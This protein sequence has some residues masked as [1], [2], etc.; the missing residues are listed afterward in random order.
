[1][2]HTAQTIFSQA[3]ISLPPNYEKMQEE[4]EVAVLGATQNLVPA[5]TTV[6]NIRSDTAVPDHVVW[7]LF[8]TIFMNACC[9][10]FIAFAYSIK[11]R[12]RKMVG[13][14]IG[15]Q[16]YA[17]TAKCLNISALVLSIALTIGL[18]VV[19]AFTS[20]QLFKAISDLQGH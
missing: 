6:I 19:F 10:G 8:N 1:M 9:L 18:I 4:H 2:S 13:D 7:S 15:A 20:V 11:S 14:V 16:S 12:D 5:T 3:N 17:S